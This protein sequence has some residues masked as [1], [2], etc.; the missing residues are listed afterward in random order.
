MD[1]QSFQFILSGGAAGVLLWLSWAFMEGKIIPKGTHDQIVDRYE[2]QIK[3]INA[4]AIETARE[5]KAHISELLDSQRAL[6]EEQRRTIAFLT[7]PSASHMSGG[8]A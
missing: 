6:L 8:G 7:S 1:P 5:S 2:A 4:E 3:E